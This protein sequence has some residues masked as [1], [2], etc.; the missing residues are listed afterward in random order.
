MKQ[1]SPEW[2]ARRRF[3]ITGSRFGDVMAKPTTKRYQNYLDDI[4][5]G[6]M[7]VPDFDDGPKP[8]FDHG[9]NWEAR[10]LRMYE[11]ETG[12]DTGQVGFLVHPDYYFIGASPDFVECVNGVGEI[13]SRK[14]LSAFTR[15]EE[16]GLTPEH[17]AQ[18][19]GEMWVAGADYCR[20][21]NYYQNEAGT[22]RLLSICTVEPDLEYHQKLEAACLSFWAEITRRVEKE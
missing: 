16:K 7:G 6:I 2:F 22:K 11:W 12:R 10:A 21:V 19:Q 9:K 5:D 8:W 4:V 20:F 14:S 3:R 17:R 13:K 18:V 15:A 1:R